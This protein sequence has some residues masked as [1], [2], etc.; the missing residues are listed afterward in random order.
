MQED[1]LDLP[2]PFNFYRAVLKGDHLHFGLWPDG[3]TSLSMED[4]Q[5]KMFEH[6]LSFFPPPPASVL[7]VGCGLGYSAFLL[8]GKGYSV[9]AIAPSSELIAYARKKYVDSGVCFEAV[10]FFDEDKTV[11]GQE[12][13]D[14]IFFQESVQ[15]LRPLDSVIKKARGLLKDGGLIIIG[16]EVCS[17]AEVK[18]QTAVHPAIDFTMALSENGFRITENEEIGRNVA[19]TYDFIIKEFTANFNRIITSFPVNRTKEELSFFLEG[20]KK[21]K[22]WYA[23]GKFGYEIFVAKKDSFFIRPYSTGDE[24]EILPMFNE[25]FKVN[26]TLDHWFWKFRDNPYGSF[27][28]SVAIAEHSRL[29]AHYAGYPVP[30]YSALEGVKSFLSCQ[31]GDTMT[32][33]GV[34]NIGL[35][36]TGL[37]ARTAKHF[38][39][40][41]CED[42][43]PFIYGFN[44]GKI[45]K[46]GMRYLGYVYIDPVTFWVKDITQ[47]SFSRPPWITRLFGGYKIEEVREISDDW[48][49]FFNR[50]CDSYVFLVRRDGPYVKW[51]YVD[52]PDRVHRIFSVKKNGQMVGWSVFIKK[53]NKV[54]WGDAL[55][56]KNYPEAVRYLLHTLFAQEFSDCSSIEGWFSNHP[57]WWSRSLREFGFETAPEPDDLS[58]AFVLFDD[59]SLLERLQQYY[60][61]TMGDSDLF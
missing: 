60:Y 9:T 6:L 49:T 46:L 53:G 7:D 47:K 11:F 51:R 52:C 18:S 32:S 56:D 57:E 21:Q 26:R 13:Y 1:Y 31:I 41:F 14:V 35:G 48:N 12:F 37:L 43:I 22:E 25:V 17:D 28:I 45:R 2:V 5:Q 3:D 50:V 30:F 54:I 23:N 16:D 8:S 33:P 42:K 59:Q 38:Y 29:V 36:K 61:Y 20:W 34:R 58:P 40:K 24:S 10:G 19:P 55:F 44:T 15:Y 27:E 4:A 39:A